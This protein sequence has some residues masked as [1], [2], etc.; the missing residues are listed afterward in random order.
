MRFAALDD[1]LEH[2]VL[3]KLSLRDLFNV[4]CVSTSLKQ[5]VELIIDSRKMF[6]QSGDWFC[7][8]CRP[9]SVALCQHVHSLDATVARGGGV[10]A[11]LD[12]YEQDV[13]LIQHA[14]NLYA[15]D[16]TS[17][18]RRFTNIFV[19]LGDDAQFIV[20]V[21]QAAIYVYFLDMRLAA[22]YLFPSGFVCG[23]TALRGGDELVV[24]GSFDGWNGIHDEGFTAHL[25]YVLKPSWRLRLT[26]DDLGF[27]LADFGMDDYFIFEG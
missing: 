22:L 15:I 20:V 1:N 7:D 4:A 5:L 6:F 26:A 24:F 17:E 10:Q 2:Y 14:D 12:P 3:T 16:V 19:V 13:V 21:R 11:M 8:R 18:A 25:V 9:T 23:V 27:S